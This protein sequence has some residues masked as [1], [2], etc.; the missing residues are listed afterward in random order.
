MRAGELAKRIQ[1]PAP[2]IIS[3]IAAAIASGRNKRLLRTLIVAGIRSG[4]AAAATLVV[5]GV[6]LWRVWKY[7][8]RFLDR[9]QGG[10]L[11]CVIVLCLVA[12]AAHRLAREPQPGRVIETAFQPSAWAKTSTAARRWLE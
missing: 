5:S 1:S 4:W 8:G 10:L 7:G 6:V 11:L 9:H 12:L 2:I 3:A